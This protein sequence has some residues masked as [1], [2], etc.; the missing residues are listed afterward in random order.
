MPIRPEQSKLARS[1]MGWTQETLARIVGLNRVSVDN[2][3][4]GQAE[5][6]PETIAAMEKAFVNQ[7][8]DFSDEY[9]VSR[10]AHG[11]QVI[12]GY[13]STI[14][15]WDHI[16]ATLKD[17]GGEILLTNV[18]ETRTLDI[19]QKYLT[20][21]LEKLKAHNI[22]ERIL[23]CEGDTNFL[24]SADSYRWLPKDLFM[25]DVANYIY[26][27]HVAQQVWGEELV[28]I[29]PSDVAY[30]DEVKRF[31]YLWKNARIPDLPPEQQRE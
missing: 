19:E 23:S 11:I 1:L 17:T 6:R 14:R 30:R 21:Y 2:F 28:I 20:D 25:P 5:F 15:L 9:S 3:E 10:Q 8:I 12:K 31:E 16:F 4:K 7:N 13:T 29:I 22:T 27:G 24:A 26:K 18:D